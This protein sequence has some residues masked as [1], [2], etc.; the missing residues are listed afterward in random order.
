MNTTIQTKLISFSGPV[1]SLLNVQGI[2]VVSL[3]NSVNAALGN[4]QLTDSNAKMGNA[5]SI[6]K[7]TGIRQSENITLRF[8]GSSNVSLRFK[9]F[10]DQIAKLTK[11][12]PSFELAQFPAE[13]SAWLA[14][15][16]ATEA[17]KA[18]KAPKAQEAAK[19]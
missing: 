2:S 15:H 12:F 13:F 10:N 4:L 9:V 17:P 16:K 18:P 19:A 6:A 8:E 7:G 1:T 11:E 5:R 3:L 14:K